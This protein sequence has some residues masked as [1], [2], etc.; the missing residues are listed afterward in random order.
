MSSENVRCIEYNDRNQG[1]IV[2]FES[3]STCEYTPVSKDIYNDLLD[4]EYLSK[5]VHNVIRSGNIVGVLK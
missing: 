4:T 5:A 2:M 1:L 3:G